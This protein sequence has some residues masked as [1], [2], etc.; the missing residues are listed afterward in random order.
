M[1]RYIAGV[2]ARGMLNMNDMEILQA[3][4][5]TLPN[6]RRCRRV[7]ITHATSRPIVCKVEGD[8][9]E[10]CSICLEKFKLNEKMMVLP[11][12]ENTLGHRF[13]EKCIGPW[14]IQ[15]RNCP[16]CRKTY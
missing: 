3:Q 5:L 4:L 9:E 10:K 12:D 2:I 8:I 1:D 13:H 11:C 6:V 7:N 15:N 14:I 16:M